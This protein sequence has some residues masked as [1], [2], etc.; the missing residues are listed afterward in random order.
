ML[1][2]DVIQA[3]FC[4][5]SWYLLIGFAIVGAIYV[6]TWIVGKGR[7]DDDFTVVLAAVCAW[8]LITV[9]AVL[10][11]LMFVVMWVVGKFRRQEENSRGG[12]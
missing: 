2:P 4:V 12:D 6:F 11:T 1:S 10:M 5:G 3:A 7:K 9:V 8:P